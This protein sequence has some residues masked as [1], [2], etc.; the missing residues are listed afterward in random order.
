MWIET[1]TLRGLDDVGAQ[2]EAAGVKRE[3]AED[4]AWLN[5]DTGALLVLA[6]HGGWRHPESSWFKVYFRAPGATAMVDV[7]HGLTGVTAFPFDTSKTGSDTYVEAMRR[8]RARVNKALGIVPD[9]PAPAPALADGLLMEAP[10]APR[11]W[12]SRLLDSR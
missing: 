2:L 10:P 3:D 11:S 7:T 1:D 6:D 8:G 9:E 5:L 4:T 12:L